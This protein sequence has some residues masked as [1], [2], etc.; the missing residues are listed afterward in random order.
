MTA[1][2]AGRKTTGEAQHDAEELRLLRTVATEAEVWRR[3]L[4]EPRPG[5]RAVV[6]AL[7]AL[8]TYRVCRGQKNKKG[9]P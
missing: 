5:E 6:D 7:W 8:A 9:G 4:I 1:K 2:R 3:T